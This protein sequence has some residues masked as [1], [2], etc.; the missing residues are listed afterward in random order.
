MEDNVALEHV[1]VSP[2]VE[3]ALP[4]LKLKYT[5]AVKGAKTRIL[6]M[7]M[8]GF[9]SFASKTELPFGERY[10]CIIG[11]NGSGKSNVLDSLC[12][13]LGKTSAKSMRAE[14][15]ANLIYNGGKTKNPAKEGEVSIHFDNSEKA[16]PLDAPEAVVTRIIKQNGTSVYKINGETTTRN[17]VLEL[18]LSAR[19][20]PDGYNII[21]Q[22]DITA[23]IEMSP[24]N[25]RMIIEEISGIGEYEDKRH[26]AALELDKVD[27]QLKESDI[28]LAERGT[29]LKELKKE[30]DQAQK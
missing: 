8:K 14:K 27:T 15:S 22:G 20:D 21:L 3:E 5:G 28:I 26:K 17:Q 29:Y 7:V 18:L 1:D 10:N 13:V 30:R 6:K 9:K 23:L 11:P 25:R 12:F 4:H 2:T 16:F 24:D 19:I